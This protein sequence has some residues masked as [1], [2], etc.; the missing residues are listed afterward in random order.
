MSQQRSAI[1]VVRSL[2]FES[3]RQF[4]FLHINSRKL[5][6]RLIIFS[7]RESNMVWYLI[8]AKGASKL[9]T[10]ASV[11]TEPYEKAFLQR[12]LKA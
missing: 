5:P 10:Q 8:G 12:V 7:S 9:Q 1:T 4:G 6:R 2:F 3:D 11:Q